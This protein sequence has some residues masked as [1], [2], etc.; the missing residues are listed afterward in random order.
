MKVSICSLRDRKDKA[1]SCDSS[2]DILFYLRLF[3]KVLFFSN[4]TYIRKYV[5]PM[6][7]KSHTAIRRFYKLFNLRLKNGCLNVSTYGYSKM[8]WR[9]FLE[10]RI[11]I[12]SEILLNSTT[13]HGFP[14]AM[15]VGIMQIMEDFLVA[16]SIDKSSFLMIS[17]Q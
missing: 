8:T 7:I 10:K 17:R 2:V 3:F 5:W 14:Q 4:D 11:R 12:V 1:A 15:I 13:R 6:I 16:P 9:R